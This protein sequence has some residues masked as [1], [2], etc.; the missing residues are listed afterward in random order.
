LRIPVAL[1]LLRPLRTLSKGLVKRFKREAQALARLRHPNIISIRHIG[2]QDDLW[3]FTMDYVIGRSLRDLIQDQELPLR[4]ALEILEKVARAIHVAHRQEV[5]HRDLKPSNILIDR[6]GEP[7]VT[8]FGLARDLKTEF[9]LSRSQTALGTPTYMSPEQARGHSRSAGPPSDVYSMGVILYE[10]LVG[11]PPFQA[12]TIGE[13]F[14]MIVHEEPV[15]PRR[16]NRAIPVDVETICLKCLQK[17]QV[18][19]Y[20]SAGDL[21]ADLRHVLNGEPIAASRASRSYRFRKQLARH[22]AV[23]AAVC[24]TALITAAGVLAAFGRFDGPTKPRRRVQTDPSFFCSSRVEDGRFVQAFDGA[25]RPLWRRDMGSAVT[26]HTDWWTT[27]AG[28]RVVVGLSGSAGSPGAVVTLDATGDEI[29]RFETVKQSPEGRQVALAVR[30]LLVCNLLPS[31]GQEVAAACTNHLNAS[32]IYVLSRDGR[33]LKGTWFHGVLAGMTSVAMADRNGGRDILV[34]WGYCGHLESSGTNHYIFPEKAVHVVFALRPDRTHDSVAAV[35][36]ERRSPSDVLWY[37]SARRGACS[38]TQVTTSTP[39]EGMGVAKL[40]V[41]T[42]TGWSLLLDDMGRVVG[43][44]QGPDATGPCPALDSRR[45]PVRPPPADV[46]GEEEPGQGWDWRTLTWLFVG[47]GLSAAF[48]VLV[49]YTLSRPIW[50]CPDCKAEV[51]LLESR[52]GNCGMEAPAAMGCMTV[53]AVAI[54]AVLAAVIILFTGSGLMSDH[55]YHRDE[56]TSQTSRETRDRT[57][58]PLENTWKRPEAP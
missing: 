38:I 28:A 49:G 16:L 50:S 29:W 11:R 54:L 18:D 17:R 34:L 14:H 51:R 8:D 56:E 42:D 43:K 4:E 37:K 20:G 35:D 44:I 30:S 48:A 19:R 25:G 2:V 3:Y 24:C 7:I 15:P 53:V 40:K 1:K 39:E 9:S 27:D 31:P 46:D 22:S 13:Q 33:I 55:S 26:A 32:C 52:C 47:I 41:T 10:M 57:S 36:P 23:L 5:I 21:A 6:D 58:K 45:D 12:D